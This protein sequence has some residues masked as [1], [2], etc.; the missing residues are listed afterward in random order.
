MQTCFEH[1]RTPSSTLHF[2][3]GAN[4]RPS[5]AANPC[6][7]RVFIVED[8]PSIAH[9]IQVLL[10]R[11]GY[12]VG[13]QARAGD[14][15][16]L[17]IEVTRPDLVLMDI[18][19]EGDLDGIQAATV[20][21]ARF[22]IPVVFLT[23]LA[24]EATLQRSQQAGAFGYLLKP[25]E[26]ED[27][28]A[29]IDLALTKHRTET[30]LRHVDRWFA[31]AIRSIGDGLIATDSSERV[32]FLNPVAERLTGNSSRQALGRPLSQVFTLD[33]QPAPPVAHRRAQNP[34]ETNE[35]RFEASLITGSGDVIPIEC[36]A[37]PLRNAEGRTIGRVIVFRDIS[38]RHQA[39]FELHQSHEQLRALAGHL[40][41]A[42]EAERIH[43]AREIHDDLGQAL[44]GL[45]MDLVWVEKHWPAPGTPDAAENAQARLKSALQAVDAMV[46]RVRRLAS[47]LRPGILDDLGLVAALEWQAREWQE[48]TGIACHF[49]SSH[50]QIALAT[51][52]RTA[53][54]RIFQEAL[55]NVLRHAAASRVEARLTRDADHVRLSIS[56]NGRGFVEGSSGPKC[57]GVLGMRERASIAGGSVVIRGVPGAG[58]TVEATIPVSAV[59]SP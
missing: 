12:T 44:T 21:A 22:E 55:T 6:V 33:E 18:N 58:T 34:S 5:D 19:L 24:D 20:V 23:G 11:S 37:A 7:A 13:G 47:E 31:A 43:L 1:E 54:F 51:E 28:K 4:D 36:A 39:E 53:L 26:Q 15:A 8:E 38:A 52:P 35:T 40:Q 46:Q 49:S 3:P 2:A 48:R 42:R 10:A 50:D 45:R 56:D 14:E 25:F 32:T 30:Q 17:Q 29:A 16:L 27:L 59:E 57:L 41:A 9:L